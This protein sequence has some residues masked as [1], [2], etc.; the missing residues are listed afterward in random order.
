MTGC[1]VQTGD[2]AQARRITTMVALRDPA[3]VTIPYAA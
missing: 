1:I 2:C 3:E